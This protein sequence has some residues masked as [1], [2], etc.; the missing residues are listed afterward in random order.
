MAFSSNY[1]NPEYATNLVRNGQGFSP[2]LFKVDS[3]GRA[4]AA[5]DIAA[6]LLVEAF[7]PLGAGLS[8]KFEYF[9]IGAEYNAVMGARREADVLLTDGIITGGFTRGGQL[10]TL[11]VANEF[12]DWDEPW[13]ETVIGWHG[14][15]GLLEYVGGPLKSTLEYTYVGYNTNKQGRDTLNQYPD[16]LYT[17]GFTDTTAFTADADYANVYDRGRDPRSVYTEFQDRQTHIAVVNVQYLVPDSPGAVLALKG[18]GG[19]P[20]QAQGQQPGRR[21]RRHH[22][23]GLRPADAAAHQR[24]QDQPGLRVHPVAGGPAERHAG[25]RVL[26]LAHQAPHRARRPQLRLRRRPLLL[27]AGVLP[28]GPAPRRAGLLRHGLERL[29][30]QGH[31]RG[32]L[33]MRTQFLVGIVSVGIVSLAGLTGCGLEGVF[34]GAPHTP[35]ERPASAFRGTA[36]W[37]GASGAQLT[38]LDGDGNPIAPFQA[39]VAAGAYEMRLPSARYTF[40]RVQARA[41]DMVFRHV[42]PEIGEETTL[43]GIDLDARSTTEAMIVEARLSADGQRF[44]Q[45]TPSAYL[46]AQ[47]AIRADLDLPGPTRDLLLMVG[48]LVDRADPTTSSIDPDLFTVPELD[49]AFVVTRSPVTAGF[50]SRVSVDYDGDGTRDRETTAF[51]ATLAAAAQRYKPAGCPDPTRVRLVFTADFNAGCLSGN[52]T[53]VDRFKWAVDKPGKRMFFVGWVHMSPAEPAI[54]TLVGASVPNQIP[55]Y[56]DGT[57]GDEVPATASDGGPRGA[58]GPRRGAAPRL[59]VHLGPARPGL[60]RQRGVAGQLAHHRG[61]RRGRGGWRAGRV[62]LPP[63]RLRRRGHQ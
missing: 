46:G 32:G 3:A 10:P 18:A 7:D 31:V 33:V 57:I 27:H 47:A 35:Y 59:Q 55:T 22:A 20:G 5:N 25:G 45:L 39:I 56:D 51:D 50:L 44:K 4:V 41:G 61:A 49:E 30:F 54:N 16:F 53:P 60:D 11:N 1:V 8:A 2:V 62:R 13:Y 19:R 28:Q 42:V 52:G 26:R 37:V 34:A 40:V 36:G 58:G 21:L 48:R 23:A 38:G 43:R 17:H 63:R 24:A 15:T 6:K 12:V 9:N 29:A 14:A